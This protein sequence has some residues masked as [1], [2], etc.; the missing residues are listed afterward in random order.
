[1][2]GSGGGAGPSTVSDETA[3]NLIRLALAHEVGKRP[4]RREDIASLVL[5]EQNSRQFKSLLALTNGKLAS[6]YGM[7]LVPLPTAT[8]QISTSTSAGR[9]A[10]AA[11][12]SGS[13]NKKPP[14]SDHCY[15]LRSI[16]ERP[17]GMFHPHPDRLAL[18]AVV[19]CL[20]SLSSEHSIEESALS[21]RLS[22]LGIFAQFGDDEMRELFVEWKRQRYLVSGRRPDDGASIYTVGPRGMVEFPAESLVSFVLAL[23]QYAQQD[24][25]S[26]I[27]RLNF[28]F[29]IPSLE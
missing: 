21:D 28:S 11:G 15:I 13:A 29:G 9:K 12:A 6:T 18:L 19:I 23:A 16:I 14:S 27:E 25:E 2:E 22:D 24:T 17:A 5:G 20:I 10:V 4:L 3:F 26:M 7:Q 8:R 1:M